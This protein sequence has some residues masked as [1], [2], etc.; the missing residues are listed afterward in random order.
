M[1]SVWFSSFFFHFSRDNYG[2]PS[3]RDYSSGGG[4]GGGGAPSR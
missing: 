3:S 4:G 2:R 1:Y